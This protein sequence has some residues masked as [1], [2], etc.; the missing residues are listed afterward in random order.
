MQVWAALREIGVRMWLIPDLTKF[1][2]HSPKDRPARL[3]TRIEA[4]DIS[5]PHDYLSSGHVSRER[6]GLSLTVS[7]D[8]NQS[9][10][11]D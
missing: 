2:N 1:Q 9:F 5:E 4:A 10:A 8:F 11:N 3:H 6:A 7:E